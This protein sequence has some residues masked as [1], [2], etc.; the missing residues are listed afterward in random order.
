MGACAI[1]AARRTDVS[2]RVRRIP[3][4]FLVHAVIFPGDLL[5]DVERVGVEQIRYGRVFVAWE[6]RNGSWRVRRRIARPSVSAVRVS[7]VVLYLG[8]VSGRVCKA[9]VVRGDL[10][11]VS[12]EPLPPELLVVTG[13]IKEGRG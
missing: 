3:D 5:L 1:S 8:R 4:G 13:I 9:S 12:V 6:S 11:V 2:N 7:A 10:Y